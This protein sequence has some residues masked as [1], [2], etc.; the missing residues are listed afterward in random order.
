MIRKNNS[1]KKDSQAEN[2]SS[3]VSNEMSSGQDPFTA[4]DHYFDELP[5]RVMDKITSEKKA[6]MFSPK[7][8]FL[9]KRAWIPLVLAASLAL[10][11]FIWK[12]SSDKNNNTT[13]NPSI[14]TISSN[15][16]DPSYAEEVLM[17]EES[18]ITEKDESQIDLNSISLALNNTDTASITTDDKIQYLLN[19]NY[20]TEIITNL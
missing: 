19:E 8:I 5:G 14:A 3:T 7:T 17:I 6:Q 16:Y 1:K 13:V 18:A 9:L 11:I 10:L 12:P 4:P 20:D 15:E 2:H